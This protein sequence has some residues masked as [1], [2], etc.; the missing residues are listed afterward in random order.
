MKG[1]P[2][3]CRHCRGRLGHTAVHDVSRLAQTFGGPR[4]QTIVTRTLCAWNLEQPS[5]QHER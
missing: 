5:I 4:C 3:V 1:V 2:N